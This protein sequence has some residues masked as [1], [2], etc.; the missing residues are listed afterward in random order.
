MKRNRFKYHSSLAPQ[1][2]CPLLTSKAPK[3]SWLILLA[4]SQAGGL[5][6]LQQDR[7]LLLNK[8]SVRV[9]HSLRGDKRLRKRCLCVP[10][11]AFR[12]RERPSASAHWWQTV[13]HRFEPSTSTHTHKN[14]ARVKGGR[15]GEGGGQR[16]FLSS[17]GPL[18]GVR[19]GPLLSIWPP[20][21]LSGGEVGQ[22]GSMVALVSTVSVPG[23]PCL[24]KLE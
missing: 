23:A 7:S 24:Y 13:C 10:C 16:C 5:L 1:A 15:E 11:E 4:Q 17:A 2:C 8:E 21:G 6:L 9:G 18:C 19:P 20:G 12:E 3:R 14:P 22:R